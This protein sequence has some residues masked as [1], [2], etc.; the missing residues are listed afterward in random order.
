MITCR[1]KP[2][3]KFGQFKQ[4]GPGDVV[5]IDA[6][7]FPGLA[8]KLEKVN[9]LPAFVSEVSFPFLKDENP[10]VTGDPKEPV[11]THLVATNSGP[12]LVADSEPEELPKVSKV[13]VKTK[14]A[15]AEEE[16]TK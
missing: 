6:A 16:S 13:K 2:G 15:E 4:Y 10:A 5:E 1:V 11:S 3:Q 9:D 8:D 7:A 12:E 14:A